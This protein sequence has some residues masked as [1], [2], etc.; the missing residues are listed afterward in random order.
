LGKEEKMIIISEMVEELRD[1]IGTIREALD[2]CDDACVSDFGATLESKISDHVVV[3]KNNDQCEKQC[4]NRVYVYSD[5]QQ[6]SCSFWLHSA[7][8][9]VFGVLAVVPHVAPELLTSFF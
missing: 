1:V 3:K 4:E 7:V 9:V 8:T 6:S 5:D 2:Y